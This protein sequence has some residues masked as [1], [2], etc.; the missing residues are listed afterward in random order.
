MYQESI[1]VRKV[2][3][4]IPQVYYLPGMGV[5]AGFPPLK[6]FTF[7]RMYQVERGTQKFHSCQAG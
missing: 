7:C 3:I 1:A 4:L 2:I 5:A 6:L